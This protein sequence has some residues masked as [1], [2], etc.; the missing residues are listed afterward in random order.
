M[1]TPSGPPAPAAGAAAA[2]RAWACLVITTI[3]YYDKIPDDVLLDRDDAEWAAQKLDDPG[4]DA[5]QNSVKAYITF[6]MEK[7]GWN[8]AARR[9][10]IV[11]HNFDVMSGE[12]GNGFELVALTE[13]LDKLSGV[14]SATEPEKRFHDWIASRYAVPDNV[15]GIDSR[16]DEMKDGVGPDLVSQAVAAFDEQAR[17][18]NVPDILIAND[19]GFWII[20]AGI[21][22]CDYD[23]DC[24]ST[25]MKKF[26]DQRMYERDGREE[27]PI[28]ET[29]HPMLEYFLPLAHAA[30]VSAQHETYVYIEPG[31]CNYGTCKVMDRETTT[32]VYQFGLSTRDETGPVPR[33]HALGNSIDMYLSSCGYGASTFTT[34]NGE[35]QI[36]H[37]IYW[38]G[39]DEGYGCVYD[40]AFNKRLPTDSDAPWIGDLTGTSDA[41]VNR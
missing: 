19:T 22:A 41:Y 1:T 21:A 40:Y 38:R 39:Y 37:P 27:P 6:D 16:I 23:P 13:A 4:F 34:I 2:S 20:T 25:F 11:T 15:T 36:G 8:E 3:F 24:D 31:S 17:H 32:G 35:F 33:R 5:K 14:Y 29:H 18:G 26:R 7:N 12:A 10:V 30:R 9:T 28:T